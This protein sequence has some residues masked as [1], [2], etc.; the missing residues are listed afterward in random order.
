MP[1][2]PIIGTHYQ[3]WS[4]HFCAYYILCSSLLQCN[5]IIIICNYII[6]MQL[7]HISCI[8]NYIIYMQLHHIYACRSEI[9]TS[10]C[11][12]NISATSS[13]FENNRKAKVQFSSRQCIPQRALQCRENCLQI[14]F[15]C[16]SGSGWGL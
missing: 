9:M 5:C 2:A 11:Y 16:N 4:T 7:H 6:Y 15:I 1:H 10:L 12:I 8:C 13:G 3:H 14:L